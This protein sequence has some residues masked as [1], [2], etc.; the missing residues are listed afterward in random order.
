MSRKLLCGGWGRWGRANPVSPRPR[1]SA[2][3]HIRLGRADAAAQHAAGGRGEEAMHR[4]LCGE[5]G[6]A[7]PSTSVSSGRLGGGAA[8]E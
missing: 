5:R 7:G 6:R 4:A 2:M 3:I 8:V 1:S